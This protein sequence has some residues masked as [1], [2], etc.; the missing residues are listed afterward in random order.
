MQQKKVNVIGGGLAGCEAAYQLSKYGIPVRLYEMKPQK[1]TPA[2]S[3]LELAELV[4]SNSLRSDR[5]SNAVGL[6][7][8]E[9]RKFDSLIM[10][11]ADETRVPAGGALAVNREDFSA[12][13]TKELERNGLIEIVREEVVDLTA[14]DADEIVIV[15]AGP[16]ASAGLMNSVRTL[17][18]D[19]CLHFFD[20]AAPIVSARSIDMDKA[21]IASRYDR[22]NDYVN[23]PMTREEYDVFYHALVG[24]ECAPLK[25]FENQ[26]VFEGCMP[27]ETMAG[28]GYETL[29]FGPLKPKGLRDPKSDKR[30]YAVVQLRMEDAEGSMYNMVGFQTHLKFKEQQRVFGLIPAL[31]KAEFLRYGVMHRNTFLKSPDLL[32]KYYR[33]RNKPNIRFAGQITGVEGYV[34]SASSGLLCGQYVACE[35]LGMPLPDFNDQT[36]IG[37]LA[38]HISGSTS[39]NFQPMNI[40]YGIMRPLDHKV[41][42]KEER[43]LEISMRALTKVSEIIAQY[44]LK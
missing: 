11:A 16:L 36:A 32:D 33:L 43:N 27:V 42:G 30:P 15:A 19:E 21:F 24:A 40:N 4:C 26:E 34:E 35:C 22:G 10:R 2:H 41:R 1:M 25:G 29:L 5:L 39:G 8:Q 17:T 37:A 13:V 3:R 31:A 44:H 9:M 18:G 23:C 28:R 14:F 38:L 20:A 6:L 7:K 12:Y